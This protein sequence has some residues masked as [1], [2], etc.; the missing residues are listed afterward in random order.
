[1]KLLTGKA[2]NANQQAESRAGK[3]KAVVDLTADDFSQSQVATLGA[4]VLALFGLASASLP[5]VKRKDISLASAVPLWVA[6]LAATAGLLFCLPPDMRLSL[7]APIATLVMLALLP[8]FTT[9]PALRLLR[10][11]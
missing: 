5:S 4:A 11:N 10:T 9:A 2:I 8:F 6:G 1:L 3:A 7:G